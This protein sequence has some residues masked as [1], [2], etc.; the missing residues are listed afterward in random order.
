MAQF[1]TGALAAIYLK[2][3]LDTPNKMDSY[4][5]EE[6]SKALLKEGLLLSPQDDNIYHVINKTGQSNSLYLSFGMCKYSVQVASRPKECVSLSGLAPVLA[7]RNRAV[8]RRFFG[9]LVATLDARSLPCILSETLT[10]V[11][12]KF[13]RQ[14]LE[15]LNFHSRELMTLAGVES[16]SKWIRM[17]K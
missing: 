8:M 2:A 14:F 11:S 12:D 7:Y 16:S 15:E 6:F 10:D 17:P 5:L 1:F 3:N 13:G 4:W 9:C